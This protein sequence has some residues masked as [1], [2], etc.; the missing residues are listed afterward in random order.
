MIDI[1]NITVT[2]PDK[3]RAVEDFSLSVRKG[4]N[5]ALIGANGAGKTSLIMALMGIVP[6]EGS[7]SV[8]GERSSKETMAKIRRKVGA[9][10]QNPDDQLFM[11][12]IYDDI[13]FGL[14]NAGINEDEI[15][16]RINRVSERLGIESIKDKTALKLSG[17]QKRMASMAAVLVMEPEFMV[18][19]EPTAFLDPKARRSLID[20]LDK[21]P[22]GK[23][24][25]THDLSFAAQVCERTVLI[26]EGRLFA[27]G[28]SKELLFDEK[29]MEECGVEAIGVYEGENRWI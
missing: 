10:F 27:D 12:C 14:R 20:V 16:I 28:R 1:R 8:C 19:D 3:T 9:V 13:A 29:L 4:E 2:Y 25:A 15:R 22:C 21:I 26:K 24:I 23:I 5:V 17:G 11:S 18:F 7:M 6:W